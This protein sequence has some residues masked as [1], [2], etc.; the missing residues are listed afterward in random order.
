MSN[1]VNNLLNL[2]IVPFKDNGI[3]VLTAGILACVW[4]FRSIHN[5]IV[6]KYYG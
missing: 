3:F 5:L 2:C 4:L 1:F 6:G